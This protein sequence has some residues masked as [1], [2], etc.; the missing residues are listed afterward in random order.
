M[1]LFIVWGVEVMG[2]A[3]AATGFL[4]LMP[5]K[6]MLKSTIDISLLYHCVTIRSYFKFPDAQ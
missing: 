3:A 2:P 1:Q 6:S 4:N 5:A